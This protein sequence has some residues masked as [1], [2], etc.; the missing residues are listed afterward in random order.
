MIVHISISTVCWVTPA[1]FT[2][3]MPSLMYYDLQGTDMGWHYGIHPL[4]LV[5]HNN[6]TMHAK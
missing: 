4:R 3:Q 5:Y 6:G 1:I 2:V